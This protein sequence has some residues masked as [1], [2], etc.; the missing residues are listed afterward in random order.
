MTN[1]IKDVAGPGDLND[2][3]DKAIYDKLKAWRLKKTKKENLSAA[4]QIFNNAVMASIAASHKAIHNM[5][6]LKMIRGISD[7]IV[8]CDGGEIMEII[9]GGPPE[10]QEEEFLINVRWDRLTEEEKAILRKHGSR[11]ARICD[12]KSPPKSEEEIRVVKV[13][14]G[15]VDP[16]T[17]IEKAWAK[18]L[19]E[20]EIQK[21]RD[22]ID[23]LLGHHGKIKFAS[24]RED[25]K[26]IRRGYLGNSK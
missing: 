12:D 23:D 5:D 3:D 17:D 2:P 10:N 25:F 1:K 8:S 22:P 13:S 18:Y 20:L 9:K 4:Y 6:D 19:D 7:G 14:N 11:L 24:D 16:E 21:R 26:K 15:E